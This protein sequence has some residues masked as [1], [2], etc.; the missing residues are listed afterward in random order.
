MTRKDPSIPVHD[1]DQFSV[2]EPQTDRLYL[3]DAGV[4]HDFVGKFAD[5]VIRAYDRY[6]SGAVG[7]ADAQAHIE[8]LVKEYGGAFM[9]RD[10]RYQIA[11][12][13]G[14]RMQ[15]RLLAT[16]PPLRSDED[17]GEGLF[18]FLA[19]QCVKAALSMANGMPPEVAGPKLKELLDEYRGRI[20]GVIV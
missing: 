8:E 20:L 15:G 1:P 7:A 9:G 19:V 14:Q 13:Q 4:V 11:P 6:L 2:D 17:P 16:I 3:G 18:R 10:P 5:D 12:W